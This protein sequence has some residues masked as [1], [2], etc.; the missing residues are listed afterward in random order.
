MGVIDVFYTQ[1]AN[2]EF[3]RGGRNATR[4]ILE[5]AK[6][7]Q[8]KLKEWFSKLPAV[9]RMDAYT[10][11]KLSSNGYLHLAYF[12]TEISIHR[13]IVQSLQPSSTDPYVLYFASATNFALINT[14]GNLLRATAPGEEEAGFYSCRLK[15]YRWALGA[16]C[17]RAEWLEGA[18]RM[19]DATDNLVDG[20]GHRQQNVPHTINEEMEGDGEGEY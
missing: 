10:P 14:F 19:L 3:E 9:A 17:R 7:V 16:S 1:R 2:A 18:V 5:R 4:L 15:E 6:P 8:L 12:A 20:L 11:G 13:R